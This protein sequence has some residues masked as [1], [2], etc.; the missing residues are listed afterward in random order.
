M[1]IK[2][3]GYII[4]KEFL[5]A[6]ITKLSQNAFHANLEE[7]QGKEKS[8]NPGALLMVAGEG[9]EPTTSGL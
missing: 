8:P 9:L 3:A 4:K 1:S 6:T 7:Q 2:K 5:K